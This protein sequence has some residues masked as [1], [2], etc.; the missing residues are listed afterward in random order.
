MPRPRSAAIARKSCG[1]PRNWIRSFSNTSI[2]SK[3][4]AA[5]ASSF[6]ASV[7]GIETVAIDLRTALVRRHDP[8]ET[9]EGQRIAMDAE[10]DD[11][12]LRDG[13]QPRVMPKRLARVDV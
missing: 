5:I 8:R 3:R 4:A 10:T 7:P 12:G 9:G 11:D 1:G 13:R 6:S 2:A